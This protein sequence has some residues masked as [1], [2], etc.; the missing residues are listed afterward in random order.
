MLDSSVGSVV[1]NFYSYCC[2]KFYI[3]CIFAWGAPGTSKLPVRTSAMPLTLCH[4]LAAR[5]TAAYTYA[6]STSH[7]IRLTA[8]K[9]GDG[10]SAD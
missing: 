3:L 1:P 5:S 4:T 6:G 8:E 10:R 7:L 2:S 9:G